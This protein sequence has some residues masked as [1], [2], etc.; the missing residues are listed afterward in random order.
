MPELKL[1]GKNSSCCCKEIQPNNQQTDVDLI[2]IDVKTAW[3]LLGEIIGK[4][5]QDELINQLFSQFCLGK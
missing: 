3:N 1:I 2:E 5:Y 4:T